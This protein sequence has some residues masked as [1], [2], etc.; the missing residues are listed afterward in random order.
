MSSVDTKA[1]IGPLGAVVV[2]AGASD[3]AASASSSGRGGSDGDSDLET[4]SVG[5]SG[6][7]PP[8]LQRTGS[9]YN[10]RAARARWGLLGLASL[11]SMLQP[12]ANT[13]YMPSLATIRDDL[14]T[15]QTLAAASISVYMFALGL[16]SLLWGPV[17]D[18]WG[19]RLTLYCSCVLFLGFTAACAFSRGIA[20]LIAFRALQGAAI[21]AFGVSAVAIVADV[22]PPES[23][24]RA[25]G[26]ATIPVLVG[27]VI[28]PMLG[29]VLSQAFG[30]R[31]TFSAMAILGV[32]IL[33]AVFLFLE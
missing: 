8:D 26:L 14:N 16:G 30:W 11:V 19:R 18:R 12:F 27:P 22:F 33:L 9:I 25:M 28:G 2:N 31:S 10:V 6:E 17:A 4:I 15:T 29:G 7:L 5:A 24:G 20:Q 1:N 3:S 21:S 32:V 13:M 23:R